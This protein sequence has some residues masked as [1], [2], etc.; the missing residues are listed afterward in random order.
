VEEF[1]D[2][3]NELKAA[4]QLN[5]FYLYGHSWGTALALECYSA[6]TNGIRGLIFNS[7]YFS[8]AIWEADADSLITLLPIETQEAIKLGEATGN[9][10]SNA[11]QDANK[12]YL[13]NYGLR[14]KP[15]TPKR[16]MKPARG[17]YFM[18]NY[19]WGPT[20][21]T[22]TGT[23]KTYNSIAKLKKVNIPV[24]FI[25][26][27][28]DEARPSTVKNFQN[29]VPHSEFEI[30]KGAGHATMHDNLR[31]NKKAIR[32]FLKEN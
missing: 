18:Y 20:E 9:Y 6:D 19:M 26:G 21:F 12:V 15:L 23:L 29:M 17:N 16:N 11:Y 22:A 13:K 2:Q 28:F 30:I 8:T 10:K 27:E 25:T 24:L 7:P 32:K 14:K 4:L 31:K 5:E 1:V 3:F